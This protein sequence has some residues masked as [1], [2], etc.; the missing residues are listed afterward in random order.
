M[1]GKSHTRRDV[2]TGRIV[3]P[4]T[5]SPEFH[6]SSLVVHVRPEHLD[7]VLAALADMPGVETHG[8][9][10]SGKLVVTLETASEQ[11]VVQHM[12]TIGELP[13]VLS[14]ALVFHHVEPGSGPD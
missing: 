4:S 7:G 5:A 3:P 14:T 6:V 1:A 13:G 10:P 8:T 2:L 12:G 11:D 9:A